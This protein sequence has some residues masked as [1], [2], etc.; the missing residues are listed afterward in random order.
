MNLILLGAQ[1]AERWVTVGFNLE[2]SYYKELES[3]IKSS[4]VDQSTYLRKVFLNHLK[5]KPLNSSTPLS[6][7]VHG[8][9]SRLLMFKLEDQERRKLEQRARTCGV[10]LSVYLRGIII[11]HLNNK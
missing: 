11:E 6:N 9:R 10:Y 3:I 7:Y 2:E 8:E 1:E 4:G 5:D